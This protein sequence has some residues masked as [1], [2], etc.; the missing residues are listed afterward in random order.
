MITMTY[1]KPELVRLVD[2]VDAVRTGGVLKD[3][4]PTDSKGSSQQNS[5]NA[6][7]ADE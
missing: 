4:S 3:Q 5:I 7:E 6:Y 2:A 1:N